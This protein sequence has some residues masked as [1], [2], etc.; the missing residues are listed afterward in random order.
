MILHVAVI[1]GLF[2]EETV[3]IASPL[4][5]AVTKPAWSMVAIVSSLETHES[6]VSVAFF[7]KTLAIS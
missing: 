2:I 7:G 4:A 6:L 1:L 5:T 3:M